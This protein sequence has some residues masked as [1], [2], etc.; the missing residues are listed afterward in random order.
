M[1]LAGVVLVYCSCGSSSTPNPD[2]AGS[3]CPDLSGTWRFGASC[4]SPH[5]FS[6]SSFAA[7]VSQNGCA[8]TLTQK[9]DNTPTEWVST[10]TVDQDGKTTLAGDFG[11]T[12]ETGWTGQVAG[13]AWTGTIANDAE[14]CTIEAQHI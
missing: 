13:G 9:D 10:G 1:V 2:A 14:I 5:S 7:G 8:I 11:F 3:G 6:A 12:D 4:E